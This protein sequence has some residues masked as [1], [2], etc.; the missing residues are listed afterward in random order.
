M[1]TAQPG[2][3]ADGAGLAPAPAVETPD[4]DTPA[5]A[6]VAVKPNVPSM[7]CESELTTRQVTV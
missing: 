2:T 3:P 4:G 5:A 1:G 7:G 6:A